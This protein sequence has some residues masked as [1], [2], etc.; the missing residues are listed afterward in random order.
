MTALTHLTE[1]GDAHMVD[2]SAK[3]VTV[4]AARARASV[5]A[6]A[7]ALALLREGA[8]P[9]GD[10]LAVARIAGIAGAK[11]TPALIP[12]CH[13]IGLTNVEVTAQVMDR[14]VRL[15]ASARA[16]GR[17]GVEM[18]ALTAATVAGL[19][20]IDM[21]K[22][23]DRSATLASIQVVAKSGGRSGDW[24]LEL[25]RAAVVTVSDRSTAG[26][27]PDTSGP[28]LV[29]GLRTAGFI[30]DAAAVVPD[31]VAAIREAVMACVTEGAGLVLTTGGTGLGPRDH[32]PE[33]L[34]ELFDA[35]A[36][37]LADLLRRVTGNTF[38]ALSRG[39]AGLIGRSLVIALPGSPAA[40]EDALA[41][42]GPLFPHLIAQLAGGD[43]EPPA[44]VVVATEVTSD[45][46]EPERLRARLA[47]ATA[48]AAVVFVGTV[49]DHDNGRTV[50]GLNYEAHPDAAAQLDT[51]AKAVAHAHPDVTGL[52]AAHRTG[53]LDVGEVAF[54]AA[55]AAPHRAGAFAAC[56]ELV[57]LV[58][59]RLPVWKQQFFTDGTDEWV[60]ST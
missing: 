47:A 36:P 41:A 58:K 1:R 30:C 31:E 32:T 45:A 37:G 25:G 23:I 7:E 59:A 8:L 35:P 39:V 13:P 48:G 40:A 20:L 49:R 55:V 44:P 53:H 9:K 12:L 50:T 22:G 52:A 10:A 43:H 19:A 14:S 57:D 38:A 17:T 6:S 33:A 3:P 11:Q 51:L 15:E 28:V 54:V 34:S 29:D 56:C 18:E 5:L 4:R 42:L 27:R 24:T 16:V 60:N 21:I 46:L 2:V 26:T